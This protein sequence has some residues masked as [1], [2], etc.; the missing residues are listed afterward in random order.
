MES[1]QSCL[2]FSIAAFQQSTQESSLDPAKL[3]P[4]LCACMQ[5]PRFRR[6]CAPLLLEGPSCPVY[7]E[8]SVSS[9]GLFHFSPASTVALIDLVIANRVSTSSSALST[10]RKRRKL[11]S[12]PSPILA[13]HAPLKKAEGL[14]FRG[15]NRNPSCIL[16]AF[17]RLLDLCGNVFDF[18]FGESNAYTIATGG[19]QKYSQEL[20]YRIFTRYPVEVVSQYLRLP[21]TPRTDSF[22]S[23]GKDTPSYVPEQNVEARKNVITALVAAVLNVEDV[24]FTEMSAWDVCRRLVVFYPNLIRPLLPALNSILGRKLMWH[25]ASKSPSPRLDASLL[26]TLRIFER[27]L[28]SIVETSELVSF[29]RLCFDY[30]QQCSAGPGAVVAVLPELLSFLLSCIH[31]RNCSPDVR[32]LVVANTDLLSSLVQKGAGNASALNQLEAACRVAS[33][34]AAIQSD[35]KITMHTI[36]RNMSLLQRKN[37]HGFKAAIENLDFLCQSKPKLFRSEAEYESLYRVKQ[38]LVQTMTSAS[39]RATKLQACATLLNIMHAEPSCDTGQYVK[40]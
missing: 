31:L 12:S 13:F 38:I 37:V 2:S 10:S 39:D 23:Q 28:P 16:A 24:D 40:V 27:F 1:I 14:L 36:E 17:V 5:H 22:S 34:R 6:F 33:K 18:S 19:Q 3:L 15:L 26:A 4:L 21:C 32:S 7:D 9:I 11:S 8:P 35:E 20:L 30:V 29:V 25:A